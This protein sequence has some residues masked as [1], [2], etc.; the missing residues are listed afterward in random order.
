MKKIAEH[1]AI[2]MDG[3]GRWAKKRNMPRSYGHK[4]GSE[5]VISIVKYAD[6]IGIKYLTLYAFSTENWKRSKKEID[7]IM[8]LLVKFIDEKIDELFSENVK[9]RIL[10]DISVLPQKTMEKV[11]YAVNKT[12]KNNGLILNIALNYGGRDEIVRSI[13]KIISSGY[14]ADE[15]TEKLISDNLYTKDIPDPD[16]LIRPGGEKRIS[17]FLIY[18]SAYSEL[19]FSDVLWPDFDTFEFSRALDEYSRRKRRFGGID[20]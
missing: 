18:Q 14:S 17:N 16:L 13:K 1:V 3:N 12:E 8:M 2:I 11:I 10:G 15:I 20:E 6:K 7:Y 5:N 19:Y 9:L 4:V